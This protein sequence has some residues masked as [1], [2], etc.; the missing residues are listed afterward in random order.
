MSKII[1]GNYNC[2]KHG[3]IEWSYYLQ[4]SC[5]TNIKWANVKN[6]LGV[7]KEKEKYKVTIK[8]PNCVQPY[9]EYFSQDEIIIEND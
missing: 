6:C 3:E 7:K 4:D 8:C 9:I 5:Y 2:P 1:K